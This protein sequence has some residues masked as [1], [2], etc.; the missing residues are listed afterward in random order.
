VLLSLPF[1]A[2]WAFLGLKLSGAWASVS[3]VWIFAPLWVSAAAIAI[4]VVT[5]MVV[6]VFIGK[7]AV[8]QQKRHESMMNHFLDK[9]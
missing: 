3:W 4:G 8:K 9:W 6:G 2:F 7:A 1:L 5:A